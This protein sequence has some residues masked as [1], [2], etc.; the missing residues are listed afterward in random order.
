MYKLVEP[1]V[2]W[3]SMVFFPFALYQYPTYTLFLILVGKYVPGLKCVKNMV[4]MYRNTNIHIIHTFP[5]IDILYATK[6]HLAPSPSIEPSPLDTSYQMK[7][8]IYLMAPHG[9]FGIGAKRIL[10]GTI[11]PSNTVVLF[12]NMLYWCAPGATWSTNALGHET[13]PLTNKTI[14]KLMEQGRN[15]ALLPGGFVEAA[16]TTSGWESLYVDKIPY[17]TKKCATY[18]YNLKYVIIYNGSTFYKHHDVCTESRTTMAYMGLPT[19]FVTPTNI[20]GRVTHDDIAVRT[21]RIHPD[22]S[23]E[24]IKTAITDVYTSDQQVLQN[25]HGMTV[26]RLLIQSRL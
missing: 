13:A 3:G 16:S 22:S 1:L 12:D 15:I 17:Y 19:P 24:D 14:K 25:E 4:L 2:T 10:G 26:K 5:E 7:P 21:L 9:V 8:T 6:S 20:G 23:L 18:G 11:I